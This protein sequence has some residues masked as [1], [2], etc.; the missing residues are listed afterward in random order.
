MIP[1]HENPLS[2]DGSEYLLEYELGR[3]S[4]ELLAAKPP[5]WESV[6]DQGI[7]GSALALLNQCGRPRTLWHLRRVAEGAVGVFCSANTPRGETTSGW[8]GGSVVS[9]GSGAF[10]DQVRPF[11]FER[12]LGAC[13]TLRRPDMARALAGTLD[14]LL[15]SEWSS[16]K[17]RRAFSRTLNQV[18]FGHE[19]WAREDLTQVF[20]LAADVRDSSA[21]EYREQLILP[22]ARLVGAYLDRDVDRFNAELSDGMNR[23]RA[24][25]GKTESRARDPLG[26]VAWLQLGLC[27]LAHDAGMKIDVECD[28]IPGWLFRKEWDEVPATPNG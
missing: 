7:R 19:S 18:A 20:A 14:V 13:W 12:G 26:R 11:T 10:L 5:L 15:L 8:L 24:Y 21:A 2:G 3:H 16:V 9:V 1:V 22:Q 6:H 23:H 4:A 17:Y 27:S 25:W 28:Y